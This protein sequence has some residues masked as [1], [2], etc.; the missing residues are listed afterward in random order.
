MN[1]RS[2][3]GLSGPGVGQLRTSLLVLLVILVPFLALPLIPVVRHRPDIMLWGW[4]LNGT[5]SVL[6]SVAAIYLA[7]HKGTP[8]SFAIGAAS[9]FLPG[10]LIQVFRLRAVPY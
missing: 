10:I 9:Y 4:P 2:N 8:A 1:R 5:F 7:I 6:A 3:V